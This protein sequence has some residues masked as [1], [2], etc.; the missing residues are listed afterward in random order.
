MRRQQFSIKGVM[1]AWR[2]W[3]QFQRAHSIHKQRSKERVRRKRDDLL[4]QAN[5]AAWKGNLFGLWKV[6]KQ[7]APKAPRKRLQLH[8]EGRI[9]STDEDV[10]HYCQVG[11]QCSHTVV[12]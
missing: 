5:A 11:T 4:E 6:V 3:V 2:L 8:K 1:T 10:K 9:L 12:V 7:L